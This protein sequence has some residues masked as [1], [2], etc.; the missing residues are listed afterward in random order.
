MNSFSDSAI[1][2]PPAD[3]CI[4]TLQTLSNKYEHLSDSRKVNPP[5]AEAV[6]NSFKSKLINLVSS[7][8]SFYD[9][10]SASDDEVEWTTLPSDCAYDSS[11][12]NYLSIPSSVTTTSCY[13]TKP[14]DELESEDDFVTGIPSPSLSPTDVVGEDAYLGSSGCTTLDTAVAGCDA[15]SSDL[16]T[17]P[18][19]IEEAL[20]RFLANNSGQVLGDTFTT[21]ASASETTLIDSTLSSAHQS[22]EH[23]AEDGEDE[24]TEDGLDAQFV[25]DSGS[26]S[27]SS[28]D[29]PE[30]PINYLTT[31]E[32]VDIF[33]KTFV[34][35][36]SWE[37]VEHHHHSKSDG[38]SSS[39][40]DGCLTPCKRKR[41]AET[42]DQLC[43]NAVQDKNA[44]PRNKAIISPRKRSRS[45][46]HNDTAAVPTAEGKKNGGL[47][48]LA[49]DTAAA[50]EHPTTAAAAAPPPPPSPMLSIAIAAGSDKAASSD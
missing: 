20:R 46:S 16:V 25:S 24:D 33:V 38:M 37:A 18:P 2:M 44:I 4:T 14:T 3:W 22:N 15:S 12:S 27:P 23:K 50:S 42:E 31:D 41:C 13:D 1:D 40:D 39:K 9:S 6:L 21:F 26:C 5:F 29:S 28:P 8:S 19:N 36:G 47:A 7:Q 17:L 48:S 49:A 30:S 11:T 32:S 43:S 10:E 45:V 34:A 35:N